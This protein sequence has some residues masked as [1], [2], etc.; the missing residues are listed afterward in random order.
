MGFK[1]KFDKSDLKRPEPVPAGI[2]DLRLISFEPVKSN[3]GESYNLYPVF[4]F[5]APGEK[6]DGKK[7]KYSFVGNSKVPQLLQ[8][9][10]HGLGELMEE[11]PDPEAPD[12]LPG[13]FDTDKLKF[14]K[15]DPTTWVYS[16]PLL[17][18][19]TKVELYIQEYNGKPSNKV[20][21]FFC[22]I[23]DCAQRFPKIQHSDNL[24]WKPAKK[25]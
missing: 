21:R 19:T 7:L 1:M 12:S 8:D 16:G 6:Y 25:G 17:N 15:D 5:V 14:N 10:S 2:Y 9:M 3:N 22:A 23:P 4:E 11:D 20:L 18:K 24:N 13:I